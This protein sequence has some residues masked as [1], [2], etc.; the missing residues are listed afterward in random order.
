M[1]VISFVPIT[2]CSRSEEE[3]SREVESILCELV[4]MREP[5]YREI[6]ARGSRSISYRYKDESTV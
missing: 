5:G 3:R 2:L 1:G 4:H 6:I